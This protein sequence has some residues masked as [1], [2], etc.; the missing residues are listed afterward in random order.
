LVRKE[1]GVSGK[2]GAATLGTLTE[3]KIS[4]PSSHSRRKRRE[5]ALLDPLGRKKKV[6]S[7]KKEKREI[8]ESKKGEVLQPSDG[9]ARGNRGGCLT[10]GRRG[11]SLHTCIYKKRK[12]DPITTDREERKE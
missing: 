3:E 7:Q 6:L 2:E 11:N 4:L 10:R 12:G 9:G 5:K 8:L 1:R